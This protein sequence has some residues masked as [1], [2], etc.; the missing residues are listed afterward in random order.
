[1]PQYKFKC[2]VCKKEFNSIVKMNQKIENCPVCN[3]IGKRIHGQDLPS[4]A[5]IEVGVGGVYRG[6]WPERKF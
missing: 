4:P 6:K 2:Y 1:M 3:K 5:Q